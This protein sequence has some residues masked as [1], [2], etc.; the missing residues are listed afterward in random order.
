MKNAYRQY[1]AKKLTDLRI[2]RR[3]T[4]TEVAER[5]GK[6]KPA[7]KAYEEGRAEPSIYTIEMLSLFYGISIDNFLYDIPLKKS[8]H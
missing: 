5:I 2:E 7:Y 4:Q 8:I 1:L 6:N 3:L